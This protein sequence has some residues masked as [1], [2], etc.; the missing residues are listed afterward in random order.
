MNPI[1]GLSIQLGL[2]HSARD[3]EGRALRKALRHF[4]WLQQVSLGVEQT[5]VSLWGHGDLSHCLYHLPDD[6]MLVLVGSPIGGIPWAQV[7]ERLNKASHPE[8][9][10][11]P[12]DGRV[13]LLK[14]SAD[15]RRWTMWNDWCGSIPVFHAQIGEGR[16]AS[17]LEPVVVAAAGY[18]SDDFF[19]PGLLS[20]LVNGHYLGD[21]TLYKDMRVVPPDCVA[22]W[23]GDGF[24]WNRL[25]TIE[26]SDERW[27]RGWDEL[28]DEAYELSRQAIAD[29][30]KT[31]PAW[32]LPLSGGLD[33]RLIAAVGAEMGVELRAY[34]YGPSV[35]EEVIYAHQ[36]AKALKL[37]WKRVDLGTDYLAKYTPIWAD[38]FGSAL[39]FH[40]MYQM[41][42]LESLRSEV[43]APIVQGF[44]GEALAGLHLPGLISAHRNGESHGPLTD[45]WIH[46]PVEE[47][48]S[49]LKVRVD[50][51]LEQVATDMESQ[52]NGVPGAWFQRLM[53][54]DLWNR[55]RLFISYQPMMYD[56]WR[57]VATP[58]HNREYARFCL[59]LP[60]LALE[61]RRLQGEML[62]RYYRDLAVIPGTY[63]ALP[64]VLSRRYIFKRG[65]AELLPRTLR[66]GPLR[67]FNPASETMGQDC[68]R[69]SGQVALWPIYEAWERLADWLEMTR[70]L[71]AH[72]A[73][74]H[75]DLKAM[76][77]LQ[78]VQTVAYRLL[79]DPSV[80]EW[81]GSSYARSAGPNHA[82]AETGNW[83]AC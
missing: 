44:L 33:S 56:Y 42:F 6:S 35:W 52:I 41:P 53:L 77:K 18:T 73:A 5:E 4:P 66:R 82:V 27:D 63:G 20:L 43:P 23:D 70:V 59:S 65:V 38:W 25:W 29:V 24:R 26:P 75:G 64:F 14:I 46:W 68:V 10:K 36:V 76:R 17:T 81:D 61:N 83:G 51:A 37:P 71:A 62:R 79:G 7:A 80:A 3:R 40:G 19:L 21:W 31:Q 55:Q 15:G 60:L 58:F 47:V 54:L 12:W 16:I 2:D 50:D 49:L 72:N 22:E 74:A 32:I 8:D 45:G 28:A 78:A 1:V 67:E 39:H 34:T 13:L 69:A 11:L 57:G 30:L 48:K 9:F